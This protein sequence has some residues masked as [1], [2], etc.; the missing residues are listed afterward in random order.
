MTP[1]EN[2]DKEYEEW[3]PPIHGRGHGL[4]NVIAFGFLGVVILLI[5]YVAWEVMT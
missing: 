2:D 1:E 4:E 5:G 3:E